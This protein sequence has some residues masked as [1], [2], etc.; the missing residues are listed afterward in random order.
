MTGSLK[1]YS[2][3]LN[4]LVCQCLASILNLFCVNFTEKKQFVHSSVIFFSIQL[5]L[6][7]HTQ[8]HKCNTR[9]WYFL[10][11]L[12]NLRSQ[13][14]GSF[15]SSFFKLLV[16]TQIQFQTFFPVYI[17]NYN[18]VKKTGIWY[19]CIWSFEFLKYHDNLRPLGLSLTP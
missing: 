10:C 18:N 17:I 1:I 14:L 8:I 2:L 12:Y 3:N 16:C 4:V 6:E 19:L 13:I 7:I 11:R 9:N 15:E 5:F